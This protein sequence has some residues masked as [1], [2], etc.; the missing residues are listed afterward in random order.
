MSAIL[1]NPKNK[2]ESRF[3]SELFAK[4]KIDAK[5]VSDEQIE[6]AGLAMLMKEVDRSDFVSEE[7]IEY[8]L[9]KD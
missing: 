2:E 9:K 4:M 5:F 1:I 3:L 6:D 7:E 8:K